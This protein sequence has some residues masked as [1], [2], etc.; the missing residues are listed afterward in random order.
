MRLSPQPAAMFYLS[1]FIHGPLLPALYVFLQFGQR[2]Q[3]YVQYCLRVK[4]TMAYAREQQDTNPL[5]HTFVQVGCG[6]AQGQRGS[7]RSWHS[8]VPLGF[9]CLQG[10]GGCR[11]GPVDS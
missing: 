10:C 3:P 4:Q 5:F 8:Q 6:G 7:G 2:F 1:E 9:S 11:R